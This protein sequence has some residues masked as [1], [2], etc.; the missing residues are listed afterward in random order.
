PLQLGDDPRQRGPDD[1]EDQ[2]DQE[3]DREDPA[4]REQ[5]VAAAQLNHRWPPPRARPSRPHSDARTGPRARAAPGLP[6]RSGR[7]PRAGTSA[8]GPPPPR[9]APPG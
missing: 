9:V 2:R 1:R 5:L 8:A 3:Q 4:E 6:G 7:R